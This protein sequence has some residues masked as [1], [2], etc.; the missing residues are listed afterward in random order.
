MNCRRI[1]L[2]LAAAMLLAEVSASAQFSA[3]RRNYVVYTATASSADY[4]YKTGEQAYLKLSATTGGAPAEGVKVIAESG[5]EMMSPDRRDTVVFRN[6]SALIPVGTSTEPGFRA[7]SFRFEVAG[8]Q[9]SDMLKVGFSTDGI[10]PLTDMPKD[11]EKFW[12]KALKEAAAIDLDPVVTPLPKYSTDKVEVFLVKLTVGPDGRNMYGYLTKPRDNGKHPVLFCPPGAGN[13]RISPTTFYSERG[14]I[15]LNVCIHSDLNPELDDA[16]FAEARKA[17][18]NYNALTTTDRDEF[19]YRSVYAGCSRCVDYLC[20]LPEWDGKNVGV[21]G[22]SQGGALTVIT[23][24][25]NPKVTFAAAFY[26]A[27]CDLTGFIHGRAGGWPK[28]FRTGD[29][30]TDAVGMLAYYDVVNFGRMLRCPTFLAYG[31]ADDTCS[32][33]SVTALRNSISAP[34]TV[35]VMYDSGHWRYGETNDEAML[36]QENLLK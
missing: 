33:T 17:S 36:W 34:L 3:P 30:P 11:F 14:Y 15:Y 28:Y 8:K 31:Y 13:N 19:Y 9:Y 27:L 21:T 10:R 26:P 22:G 16:A 4:T 18:D 25:L 20:T 7:C 6:G 23:S 1:V 5:M 12:K 29:D 24:A 35:A 32:P 2:P